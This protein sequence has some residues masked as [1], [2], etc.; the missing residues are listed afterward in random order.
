MVVRKLRKEKK[1]VSR[2]T[3][4]KLREQ[5]RCINEATYILEILPLFILHN[6]FVNQWGK[7][8]KVRAFH[9]TLI[10]LMMTIMMMMMII[11]TTTAMLRIMMIMIIIILVIIIIINS[12]S[13]FCL[14]SFDF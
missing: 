11:T 1:N 8:L 7:F 12:S 2:R 14:Y 5:N 9:I 4:L 10:F 13:A 3:L 6:Y